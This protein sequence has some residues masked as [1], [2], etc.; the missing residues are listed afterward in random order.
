MGE[1]YRSVMGMPE[2]TATQ[3]KTRCSALLTSMDGADYLALRRTQ[4]ANHFFGDRITKK[5]P[6]ERDEHGFSKNFNQSVIEKMEAIL[7]DSKSEAYIDALKLAFNKVSK[8][9]STGG[10]VDPPM[11][12]LPENCT[13][14]RYKNFV[15]TEMAYDECKICRYRDFAHKNDVFFSHQHQ[16]DISLDPNYKTNLKTMQN[17]QIAAA[18]KEVDPG[19]PEYDENSVELDEDILDE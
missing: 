18:A 19:I 10:M 16:L 8:E 15:E 6:K 13:D 17:P 1:L 7:E 5:A 11:R 12:Y 3:S 2:L 4:L 9:I 14:C